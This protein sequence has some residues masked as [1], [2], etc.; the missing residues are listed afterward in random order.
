MNGIAWIFAFGLLIINAECQICTTNSENAVSCSN[1]KSMTEIADTIKSNWTR[2]E[3][4]N[5][6]SAGAELT[7]AGQFSYNFAYITQLDFSK[8]GMLKVVDNGFSSFTSMILLNV[9]NTRISEIRQQWFGT[10]G[11]NIEH[12]NAS[13]NRIKNIK[14]E[15]IKHF[16]KLK[17][18]NISYNVIDLIDPNSF[19][20]LKKLEVLS[21]SNNLLTVANIGAIENLKTLNLR[22][23]SIVRVSDLPLNPSQ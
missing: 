4:N 9:S 17:Q 13:K 7:V 11:K 21:L 18:L 6:A 5:E 3:I 16:T 19:I 23:N 2:L 20:D 14:R 10:A 1:V 15:N 12:L 22:D 8:A